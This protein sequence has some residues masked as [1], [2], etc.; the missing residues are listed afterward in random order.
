MAYETPLEVMIGTINK[1][2]KQRDNQL[3]KIAELTLQL[4]VLQTKYGDS[5]LV[6]K[7]EKELDNAH[8]KLADAEIQLD[9]LSKTRHGGAS[10][11]NFLTDENL[12]MVKD[13]MN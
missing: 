11:D 5:F 7:L 2:K 6:E 8:N 4:K 12:E 1:L 10:L 3:N 13:A 9:L